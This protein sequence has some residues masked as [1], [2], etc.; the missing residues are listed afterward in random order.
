MQPSI[1][2]SMTGSVSL[3]STTSPY[4]QTNTHPCL[5]CKRPHFLRH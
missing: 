2:S 1:R 4:A 5:C 3:N